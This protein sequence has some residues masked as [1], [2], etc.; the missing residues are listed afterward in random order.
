MPTKKVVILHDWLTGYRGGERVLEAICEM[1]PEAPI[2]TLI[3]KKGSTSPFLESRRIITSCL[4]KVP[5]IY[6]NYRYFLPLMPLAVNSLEIPNDV[7][8]VISSSHCVIKGVKRPEEAK[9]ISYI[10]SPMRYMYDQFDNYF[11][12][13][14]LIVKLAANCLKPYLRAWDSMSNENVDCF[15]ANSSFVQAR[16]KH[17]YNK[18]SLIVHPFVDLKDFQH[19]QDKIA[20]KGDHFIMV[21]AFSPNKR[22]DLAIETFNANKKELRIIGSGSK[23]E[24]SYLRSIAGRN[25]KFLGSLKR[26][27]VVSELSKAQALIFPGVEDF[28][29]VPLESLA[30]G[31]P[32][33]AYKSGGVLDTLNEDCAIFFHELNTH[34]LQEKIEKFTAKK[35][36]T[37]FLQ[38]RAALFSKERFQS[39]IQDS[40]NE[41]YRP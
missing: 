7:E 5:G 14:S 12:S 34:S 22:V 2:Y 9:H 31:T 3:H 11:G 29:I 20:V 30:A 27:E 25:I 35:F 38:M 4:D 13:S 8:L 6:D 36:Q 28:G 16:I 24:E 41:L 17:F 40:I 19:L 18:D 21:T 26:N 15:I 1:Y 39:Q 32:V 37:R 10:H 23:E 33:I